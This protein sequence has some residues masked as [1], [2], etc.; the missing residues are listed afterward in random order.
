M[1]DFRSD[2]LTKPTKEM[3]E[4]MMHAKVGDDVLSE[5]PTVNELERLAAEKLDKE[6]ALFVPS[7]TFGN[8]LAIMTHTKRGDEII[9]KDDTHVIQYEAAASA[10]LSGVQTRTIKTKGPYLSLQEIDDH[11][12]KVY[13]V[14]QHDTGL[15]VLQNSLGNGDVMPLDA[16]ASVHA[17]LQ[18]HEVPI[19]LD[20]ARVFNAAVH[21][22]VDVKEIAKYC[23]SVMF[24]LSKGLGAPVGSILTGSEEFIFKARKGRKLMGGGMRQAGVLAAPGIIALEKM[25]KRLHTDHEHAKRLAQ[26]FSNYEAFDIRP[27]DIKTNIFYLKFNSEIADKFYQLLI[28]NEI[29]VYPP[30]NGELRFVTHYDIHE[31]DVERFIAKLPELVD[32]LK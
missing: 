15:V 14:H 27:E 10:V 6:A 13:D 5:D 2:T 9:V 12:R 16:M 28:K 17:H 32:Q 31:S 18:K 19:H 11:L 7:G 25:S 23:D 21:L 1:I 26:A 4:S 24:C 3:R 29:L 8:Q 30:R 22:N 20:G